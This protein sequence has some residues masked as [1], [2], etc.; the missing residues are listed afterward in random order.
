MRMYWFAAGRNVALCF[1]AP[2]RRLSTFST[3][4]LY[5]QCHFLTVGAFTDLVIQTLLQIDHPAIESG[6]S[7]LAAMTDERFERDVFKGGISVGD[8]SLPP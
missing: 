5:Q 8:W 3:R 4:R 7:G 6:R 1:F 2:I